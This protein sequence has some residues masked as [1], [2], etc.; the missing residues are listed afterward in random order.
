MES[1][2]R[3]G[4]TAGASG[5]RDPT[6]ASKPQAPASADFAK[7][8]PLARADA[9]RPTAPSAS[10]PTAPAA[11]PSEERVADARQRTAAAPEPAPPAV[12]TLQETIT[13]TETAEAQLRAKRQADRAEA[14]LADAAPPALGKAVGGSESARMA[15][16]A[17][18]AKQPAQLTGRITYRTRAA[19]PEGAVIDVQLLDVSRMD[20]PATT[21][22]RVEIVTRGEQVPVPFTVGYDAAAI[23]PRRRYTVQATI[24][25]E[26]RVAYRTTTAHAVL[27]SGAPAAAV[28]VVV[29]PMR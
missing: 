3:E 16:A 21:L 5:R 13:V 19:L 6:A 18:P 4:L 17:T 10:S 15:G 11:R 25:I 20:A 22:G 2:T 29:E 26:G 28:E 23:D 8:A 1:A 27:T 12:G 24:T 7:V 9:S 14:N